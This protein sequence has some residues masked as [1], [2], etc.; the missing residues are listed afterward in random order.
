MS[1]IDLPNHPDRLIFDLEPPGDRFDLLV[2]AARELRD[3]LEQFNLSVYAMSTGTHGLYVVVPLDCS[4]TFDSVN[5]FANDVVRV[6]ASENPD[7]VTIEPQRELRGER[8]FID[9]SRNAY[10][11]MMIAPYSVR[12]VPGAPVARPVFWRE[13]DDPSFNP[14]LYGMKNVSYWLDPRSDPWSGMVR[15]ARSLREPKQSIGGILAHTR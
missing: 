12:A 1:R 8:V 14:K 5:E 13:L 3:F 11:Q 15:R 4:E 9:T 10:G 6:I 2:S 7:L